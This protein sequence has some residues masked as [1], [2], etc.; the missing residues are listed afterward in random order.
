M[1]S[2]RHAMRQAAIHAATAAPPPR[3]LRAFYSAA[4]RMT[5]MIAWIKAPRAREPRC[6]VYAHLKPIITWP[7]PRVFL[8]DE[9]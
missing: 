1:M 3:L 8:L 6:L 7:V 2:Y 9:K 5:A 4:F